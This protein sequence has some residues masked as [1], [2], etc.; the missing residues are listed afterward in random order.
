MSELHSFGPCAVAAALLIAS[1]GKEDRSE[2]RGTDVSDARIERVV[3]QI[4]AQEIRCREDD[5]PDDDALATEEECIA[6]AVDFFAAEVSMDPQ[7]ADAR[8]DFE[9]CRAELE[10]E[11]DESRCEALYDVGERRCEYGLDASGEA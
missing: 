9:A 10:C 6:D 8:L 3:T 7:C 1:C 5:A 11:E 2:A 4:C